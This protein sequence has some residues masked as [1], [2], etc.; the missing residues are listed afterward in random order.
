MFLVC[1]FV[2]VVFLC[3]II[4]FKLIVLVVSFYQASRLYTFFL[5]VSALLKVAQWF[6]LALYRVRFVF[7]FLFV[8]FLFL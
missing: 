7:S 3:L 6:V 5:L 4:Y 1:S 8:C 2:G